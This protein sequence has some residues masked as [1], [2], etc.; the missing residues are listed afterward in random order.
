MHGIISTYNKVTKACTSYVLGIHSI[1]MLATRYLFVRVRVVRTG[2]SYNLIHKK[3]RQFLL[4][5]FDPLIWQDLLLFLFNL[6][7]K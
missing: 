5:C 7:F 6:Q 3:S 2:A 4:N 1:L